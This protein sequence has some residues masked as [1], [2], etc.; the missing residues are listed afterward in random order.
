MTPY[1]DD[2]QITIYCGDNVAVL[3]ELGRDVADLTVTSP[4]YDNLRDYQG[5]S[6]D[7]E[8]LSKQLF[9]TTVKGGV[10]VWVVAD[11]TINGSETGSSFRQALGF[12][13]VGFKLHDTMIYKPAGVGAKGSHK[14]YWQAFEYMFVMVNGGI[15][16]YNL[17]R[18][19]KNKT[20][21]DRRGRSGTKARGLKSRV[22]PRG[23][24]TQ[25]TGK[26]ENVWIYKTGNINGS[27]FTAHPAPFPEALARDHIISW[28]N[29]N[30]LIL[31]PFNGSGTTTKMAQLQNRKAIGIEL[32]EEYCRIAVE[33]LSHKVAYSLPPTP[34]AKNTS[35]SIQLSLI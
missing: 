2:G 13:D 24:V 7:F 14:S 27:D 8:A 25:E 4:P 19:K 31:D 12:M 6:W 10:V 3:Q 11:A 32:S 1:F 17:I 18:D 35:K 21:G 26:R 9:A 30:D 33:R 29:E 15:K 28:S 5:Y 23:F 20:A 34:T 22:V 16:T